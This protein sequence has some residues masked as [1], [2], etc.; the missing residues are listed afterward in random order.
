[1]PGQWVVDTHLYRRSDGT[2]PI[3]VTVSL[4]DLRSQDHILEQRRVVLTQQGDEKTPFRFTVDTSGNV[5]GYS[6]LPVS[7]IRS[8]TTYSG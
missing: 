1:M 6:F 2:A 4:W 5:T 7:L 8:S 3:P